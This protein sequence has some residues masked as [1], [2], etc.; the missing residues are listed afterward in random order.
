MTKK[1]RP[2]Y[3]SEVNIGI[4]VHYEYVCDTNFVVTLYQELIYIFHESL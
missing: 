3:F 4:A 1:S 2:F